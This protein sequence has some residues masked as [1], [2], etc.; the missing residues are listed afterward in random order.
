MR[1]ATWN[2]GMALHRKFEAM[3]RLKP[4]IAV[5]CECADPSACRPLPGRR[6]LA[7]MR[8]GSATIATRASRCSPSTATRC[9]WPNPSHST[10][11]H[12]AP[13]HVTGP[14]EC[15][16][17][18]VW[19]QN[20]SGGVSRKHQLGP[21]AARAHQIPGVPGGATE[22]R[23]R[24]FQQQCLLAPTRL[25]HQPRQRGR[26]LERLGLASAYHVVRG[27]QQ[28]EE[29]VPT[30]YWRDRKKDGPTYHIDY[31]FVPTRWLGQCPR[32][33]RRHIRGLVRFG[34]QRPCPDPGRRQSPARDMTPP[35]RSS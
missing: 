8:S 12:V 35:A 5:I 30:L 31:V 34:S 4:D 25:A 10:L 17:L 21:A 27:E 9:G 7:P 23:R 32:I 2:C 33:G 19:A 1:L 15:N 3:L 13:V 18:A 24:R 20:G 11:R 14:V 16:L 28:G 29:T 6:T 26:R 22:H